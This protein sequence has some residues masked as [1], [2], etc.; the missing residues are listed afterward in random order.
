MKC[1]NI[2]VMYKGGGYDGCIWCWCFFSFDSAG[3]FHNL[4]TVGRNGIETLEQAIAKMDE[5]PAEKGN[6]DHVYIYDLDKEEDIDDFQDSH[7]VP[8]VVQIVKEL[9][10]GKHGE[11]PEMWFKCDECDKK[12][13]TGHMEDWHGCGGIE[14]TADTKLCE[15]CYSAG[16]CNECGDYDTT[17]K[18]HDGVCDTCYHSSLES[19]LE[20]LDG[21]GCKVLEYNRLSNTLTEVD[22]EDSSLTGDGIKGASDSYWMVTVHCKDGIKK[23]IIDSP[24]ESTAISDVVTYLGGSN[25]YFT[26]DAE[27]LKDAVC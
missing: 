25:S 27:L 5:V 11:Y 15:N 14:S 19:I 16:C 2:L 1:K 9:N 18:D 17:V 20:S 12:S 7:A 13:D 21:D 23:F 10:S 26:A 6:R 24:R 4:Y 22:V 8:T 3:N